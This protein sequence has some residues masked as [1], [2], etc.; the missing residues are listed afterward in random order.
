MHAS[1]SPAE[2]L[3]KPAGALLGAA[4]AALLLALRLQQRAV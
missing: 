1:I 3:M 2:G 4:L